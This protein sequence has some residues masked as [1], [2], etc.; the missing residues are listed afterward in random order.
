MSP[1]QSAELRIIVQQKDRIRELEVA[2]RSVRTILASD[3]IEYDDMLDIDK[4]IY[5]A[6]APKEP[7]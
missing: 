6:L 3:S 7:T 2:L 4:I 5:E 1:E